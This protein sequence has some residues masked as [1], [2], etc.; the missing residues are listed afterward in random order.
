[1]FDSTQQ[2]KI[3]FLS[4]LNTHQSRRSDYCSFREKLFGSDGGRVYV[5]TAL[6]SQ[7]STTNAISDRSFEKDIE[8]RG[9]LLPL[10]GGRRVATFRD[11]GREAHRA[12]AQTIQQGKQEEE[13]RFDK[14]LGALDD[15]RSEGPV[16]VLATR[17]EWWC[18]CVCVCVWMRI[19]LMPAVCSSRCSKHKTTP[20]F[21]YTVWP[22]M[23]TLPS[24]V[25][26]QIG[27]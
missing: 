20:V 15:R 8:R 11:S 12:R 4:P 7:C 19:R 9:Y 1:M 14:S 27:I 17:R 24:K 13:V 3:W 23:I 2:R 22:R 18:L 25:T 6:H 21:L 26:T 5:F 16:C 10:P